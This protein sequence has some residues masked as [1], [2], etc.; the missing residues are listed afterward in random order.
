MHLKVRRCVYGTAIALALAACTRESSTDD[1]SADVNLAAHDGQSVAVLGED[2]GRSADEGAVNS[3]DLDGSAPEP[4]SDLVTNS[5]T[6][7]PASS[8]KVWVGMSGVPQGC[9]LTNYRNVDDAWIVMEQRGAKVLERTPEM[10]VVLEPSPKGPFKTVFATDEGV[11][12][13]IVAQR[14]FSALQDAAS[15]SPDE[16]A[17]K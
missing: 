13:A 15:G 11:C 2:P 16:G 10:V 14:G 6:A 8:G 1:S 17:E 7:T 5:R 3:W 4:S 12:S 9:M